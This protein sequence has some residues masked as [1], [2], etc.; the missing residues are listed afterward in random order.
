VTGPIDSVPLGG[1]LS[2]TA[3]VRDAGGAVLTGRPI[4]WTS[5]ATS[6]A[7]VGS[8]G[9]VSTVA[10]GVS[11]ITASVPVETGS[12]EV[13]TGS[14][15]VRVVSGLRLSLAPRELRLRPTDVQPLT[16]TVSGGTQTIDRTVEYLSRSPAVA[17]VSATGG[18][19]AIGTGS[20][21]IVA[22][23][24]ADT[25]VR[26][27]ISVAVLDPCSLAFTH[28]VGSITNG[29]FTTAS[30]RVDLGGQQIAFQ[31]SVVFLATAT[32]ALQYRFQSTAS[33]TDFLVPYP[34]G[35][36][37]IWIGGQLLPGANPLRGVVYV[38]PGRYFLDLWSRNLGTGTFQFETTIDPDPATLC[39]QDRYAM[40]GANF[41]VALG[42]SCT[43]LDITG[44][45]LLDVGARLSVTASSQAYPVR[46]QIYQIN[47]DGTL[48]LLSQGTASGPGVATTAVFANFG[49]RR[50]WTIRLSSPVVGAI[51]PAQISIT[52]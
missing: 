15:R 31:E 20:T 18:V 32:A 7:T 25:L 24:R 29:T 48:S 3:T 17:T 9:V 39:G 51:G 35:S 41:T 19:T 33:R 27:S 10:P 13:L 36:G 47:N 11:T 52:P 4:T 43:F 40:V 49:V 37:A 28:T 21:Q 50:N 45:T 23:M 26:D 46:L 16:A 30:C 14:F 2:L 34:E 42:G 6:I 12:A 44:M 38:R 22:R 8:T 5:S 1:T